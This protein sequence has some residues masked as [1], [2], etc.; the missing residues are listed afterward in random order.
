MATLLPSILFLTGSIG[1]ATCSWLMLVA[2]V[3][4]FT[5]TPFWMGREKTT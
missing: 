5:A 2:T 4:W 3:V 1:L